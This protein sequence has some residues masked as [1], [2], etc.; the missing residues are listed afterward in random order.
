MSTQP[1]PLPTARKTG[2][3]RTRRWRERMRAKGLV[4]RT[5]WT[6]DVNDPAFLEELRL[7]GERIRGSEDERRVME[8]IEAMYELHEPVPDWVGSE[9]DREEG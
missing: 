1:A 7:A 2:A 9:R 5:V 8:E 6:Y 4:P 3:E